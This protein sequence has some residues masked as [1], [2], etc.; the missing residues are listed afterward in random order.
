MYL[1]GRNEN[2]T[3]LLMQVQDGMLQFS[4]SDFLETDELKLTFAKVCTQV[5]IVFG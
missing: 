3:A 2:I 5:K 4:G 1:C